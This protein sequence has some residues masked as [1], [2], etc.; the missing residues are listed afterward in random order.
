MKN[1][2]KVN[3]SNDK[4]ES[5]RAVFFMVVKGNKKTMDQFEKAIEVNG[6]L[7]NIEAKK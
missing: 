4:I 6:I 5:L 1:N 3:K 7:E 2:K